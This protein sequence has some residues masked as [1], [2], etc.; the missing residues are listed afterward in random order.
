MEPIRAHRFHLPITDE[1]TLKSFVQYAW[2]V[3]IPDRQICEGHTTP[4]RAFCDAYFAKSSVSVWKASRGFGGKSYLM[5][6]LALT[7]AVTLKA[8]VNVLGGSGEQ[9]ER[10][11]EYNAQFWQHPGAPATL[12]EGDPKRETRLAWGN[13]IKALMASSRSVRGPHPVRLR[14]DEVDEVDL[15]ILDAAMGQPMSDGDIRAQTVLSSTHQYADGTMTEILRRASQKG[16]PVYHWCYRENLEPWGWL[17]VDEVEQK[18]NDVTQAMWD[19]EYELQEPNPSSRAIDSAA[20]AA[21]FNRSLGV[22]EGRNREYIELEPPQPK[23]TYVHGADWARKEDWTIICTARTDTSPKR[24]VAFERMGRLPW[25][26]MVARFD[27]RIKRY[28]GFAAH[29]G[30]GIGDVVAGYMNSSARPIMMVGRARSDMISDYIAAV[31]RGEYSAPFIR[32]MEAEHRLASVDD[33]YGSG[34]LPDSI[35][36]MSVLHSMAKVSAPTITTVSL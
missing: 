20:V 16:W 14:I 29:D 31:E 36:A 35:A 32:F 2:G 7:E 10:V 8:S 30:T 6:L 12:L 26:V 3:T 21:M 28:G 11:L 25:P 17:S 4:W 18:R 24:L 19:A 1:S 5:A 13:S 33:V 34:H 23:A 22:Y 9:S 15:S 27:D